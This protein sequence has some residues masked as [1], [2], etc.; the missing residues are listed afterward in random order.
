VESLHVESDSTGELSPVCESNES[1]DDDPEIEMVEDVD[2]LREDC[3]ASE[4]HSS[5]EEPG[6]IPDVQ[7]HIF[8]LDPDPS[9][10]VK[11]KR[12]D[13]LHMRLYSVAFETSESHDEQVKVL[14]QLQQ[15]IKFVNIEIRQLRL[16]EN[17]LLV[18]LQ[19]NAL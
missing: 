14:G 1:G 17:G 16:V 2:E 12:L 9:W 3:N 15:D 4:S 5:H 11:K 13:E 6:R 18:A 10:L 19:V 7:P 8:K